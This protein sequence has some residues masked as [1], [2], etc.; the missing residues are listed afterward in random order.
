MAT[1]RK[2]EEIET[3]LS[4][5]AN[6]RQALE[7]LLAR[8]RADISKEEA[9][10]E[11]VAYDEALARSVVIPWNV[12][13]RGAVHTSKAWEEEDVGDDAYHNADRCANTDTCWYQG[14]LD[15]VDGLCLF[16]LSTLDGFEVTLCDVCLENGHAAK[17][18]DKCPVKAPTTV[19]VDPDAY[20]PEIAER[21]R[22]AAKTGKDE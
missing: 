19:R 17:L 13:Y 8:V 5:L 11:D 10:L 1:K 12:F 3:R 14:N 9:A 7:K 2:R 22:A 21:F 18:L 15:R 6:K 20:E 4:V 16:T